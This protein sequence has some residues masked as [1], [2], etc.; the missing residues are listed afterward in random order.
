MQASGCDNPA[1]SLR[2][3]IMSRSA[4]MA[5]WSRSGSMPIRDVMGVGLGARIFE[6][7]IVTHDELEH[8]AQRRLDR[9]DADFTIALGSVAVAAGKQSALGEH[10]Q[11]ERS[12][13]R[14]LLVVEIAAGRLRDD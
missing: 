8:P 3:A 14:Q 4:M 12:A 1:F 13:G 9:G 2:S 10:R 6:C 7:E 5:H 11:V